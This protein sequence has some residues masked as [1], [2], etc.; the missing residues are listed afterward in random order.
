MAQSKADSKKSKTSSKTKTKAS[1]ASKNTVGIEKYERR[2]RLNI[3]H[4]WILALW[5]VPQKRVSRPIPH[6]PENLK[7]AET[8]ASKIELAYLSQLAG[9]GTFDLTLA[10]YGVPQPH[11]KVVG[12]DTP[13]KLTLLALFEKWVQF[14]L[15]SGQIGEV[16]YNSAYKKYIKAIKDAGKSAKSAAPP[17]DL[18]AWLTES[19]SSH[20]THCI[21][22]ATDRCVNWAIRY[23]CNPY[24]EKN[25]FQ[26]LADDI[27]VEMAVKKSKYAPSHVG[28]TTSADDD[29]DEGFQ[30]VNGKKKPVAFSMQE[31]YTIIEAFRQHPTR[32]HYANLIEFMFLTGCR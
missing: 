17:A 14:L 32:K 13:P 1:K 18:A 21:L 23:G 2:I 24:G 9:T 6:T 15:S 26:G 7:F 3:P 22:K 20:I 19:R 5:N 27:K 29:D 4:Q 28:L 16:T 12:T 11:L 31:A 25:P 30:L 8:V 10:S